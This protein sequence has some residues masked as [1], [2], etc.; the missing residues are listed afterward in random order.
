MIPESVVI[1][2]TE[3]LAASHVFHPLSGNLPLS[4][5]IP[6]GGENWHEQAA[7]FAAL[8]RR[9]MAIMEALDASEGAPPAETPHLIQPDVA[10]IDVENLEQRVQ[11]PV[12]ELEAEQQRLDRLQSYLSQVRTI[13]DVDVELEAMRNLRYLFATMGTIP[14]VNVER[15]RSS[16]EVVPSVLVVLDQENHLATVALFGTKRDA[17]IL[18]RAARSAYLNPLDL[19]DTYRGT[20][21]EVIKALQAGIERTRR[22]IRENQATIRRLHE[23]RIDH[24]RHLLWRVRASRKLVETIARYDRLH[25]GYVV[26]GWVPAADMSTLLQKVEAV[27]ED[28]TI[29][30]TMPDRHEPGETPAALHN[31]PLL[32]PF[33]TLVTNYGYPSYSETDPTL[34]TALTFSLLFGVMFG[35]V[36]HGLLL[37]LAGLLLASRRWRPLRALSALGPLL[38][39]C[40]ALATVFGFLYGSIFGFEQVIQ[41]LWMRPVEGIQNILL[42]AVGAGAIFLSLGMVINMINAALSRHWGRLLFDHNGFAGLLFYW[43]LIGLVAPRFARD[44]SIPSGPLAVLL[45][46]SGLALIFDE[47]LENL[48]EG[49]RPLVEEDTASS[50]IQGVFTLFETAI[51]LMSNT[52]S[53]VR[54]GAFAVAH[55]A[56]GLVVLILANRAGPS[57]GLGYWIVLTLGNLFVIGFEGLIVAIQT[58]RLEYYEFFGKFFSGGGVRYDPLSLVPRE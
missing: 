3:A 11:E 51:S 38:I 16:L 22:R 33:Q 43:S 27:S 25:Y 1:P 18:R 21:A 32:R 29:G 42:T 49:H 36:G 47:M 14:T 57:Q 12:R 15:L 50:L 30:T 45:V 37:A 31:P 8:E 5:Q 40:G 24:L 54:I 58:L 13:A 35:D 52:L 17:E 28:V 39:T 53:F 19:P 7:K 41:P 44:I 34:V 55:G 26:R 10:E 46:V 48:I 56:L 2:V 23:A 20:P 9:V 4:E 6:P